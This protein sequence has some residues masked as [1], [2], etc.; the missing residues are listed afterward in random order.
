MESYALFNVFSDV[1]TFVLVISSIVSIFLLRNNKSKILK[2][3]AYYLIICCLMDL[4]T[5]LIVFL[6]ESEFIEG[7]SSMILTI[8]F[9]LIELLIIGYLINKYWLKSKV[10]W[11]LMIF[12][13][14]YLLYDLFTFQSKGVLN[15]E[16]R[17]QT[18]ATILLVGLVVANL[19]KQLRRGKE[20][21]VTNQLLC[22]VFL[23]YFSIHLV[24]TVIQN[25]IINQSFTDKSFTLFYSSYVLLHIV[26]YSALT[27]ILFRNL[28]KTQLK[29]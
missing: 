2:A 21:N 4:I 12:S 7:F 23:A 6:L 11:L 17:G 19:L 22:M 29:L 3:V 28:K 26:Y 9:R 27:F 24:Y 18:V 5:A 15:Y 8:V 25:F 16:A 20:F 14:V 10:V 13:S 1:N